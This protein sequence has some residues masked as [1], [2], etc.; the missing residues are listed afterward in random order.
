VQFF[1]PIKICQKISKLLCGLFFVAL[2]FIA[3]ISY[4]SSG[5]DTGFGRNRSCDITTGDPAGLHYDAIDGGD[6]AEFV[7]TNPVCATVALTSYAAVKAG[8]A[9][10]NG[11]CGSG[12]AVPRVLPS[13]LMDAWDIVRATR[14]AATTR[15]PSCI[16]AEIVGLATFTAALTQMKIIYDIAKA[17]YDSTK[18]CGANWLKPNV[19][20][21]QI[22]TP[23]YKATVENAINTRLRTLR[24]SGSTTTPDTLKKTDKT[25][26]EWYY[27]GVEVE[28]NP[29]SGEACYDPGNILTGTV[30]ARNTTYGKQKYYLHGLELGNYNCEQYNILPGT[31]DPETK[32]AMVEYRVADYKTA[33]KCCQD[34]AQNFVCIDNSSKQVFCRAGDKCTIDNITFEAVS[35]D[36]GRYNCAQ[37]YSLCP[38]NYYLG[39]GT[40]YCDYYRDGKRGSNGTWTMITQANITTST[41]ATPTTTCDTFS[42]IRNANCTYNDKAGKCRN[43]C[44]YFRH[45]TKAADASYQ[46]KSRLGSPYFSDA[47]INFVGDS[48]NEEETVNGAE[49]LGSQRHFSA[50]I[51]QCIK[52]T[53]ENLFYN[54]AGHSECAD[55]SDY[56]AADGTCA[57]GRYGGSDSFVYKK[58]NTVKEVSFFTSVQDFLQAAVRMTLTLSVMFFGMNVLLGKTDVRNKKELMTYLLK[59]ALVTYFATGDAWQSTF[60]KGVYNTSAAFSEMVF[61]IGAQPDERQR[62]GCQFG[63]ISLL[64]DGTTVSS[65]RTYPPGKNY[66]ALWDTLDC[67]I[68]RYLGFGP[69]LSTANI[70]SLILAGFFTGAV[71]VYFAMAVMFFGFFFIVATIKALHIFLASCLAIIIMV[72]VSP[73]IIPMVLFKQSESIFKGWLKQLISFCFQPMILFAYIAI[74]TTALDKTM[75]GSATFFGNGP[76]KSMSCEKF[77]RN[78]DGTVVD[79]STVEAACDEVGQKWVDPMI[80]SFACLINVNSFG[81]MPG[82]E[83]IGISLPVI[84]ILFDT[85]LKEKIMTIIRGALVMYLLCKFMD[86]IPGITAAL[87]GG[88][89]LPSNKI[90]GPKDMFK[91]VAGLVAAAQKRAVRGLRKGSKGGG[92]KGKGAVRAGGDQGKAATDAGSEDSGGAEGSSDGESS[93]SSDSASVGVDDGSK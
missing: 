23:Y 83:V 39:G 85:N 60:F 86:E 56:P 71:G 61:K 59:I 38:Y 41:S 63:Y 30:D 11:I 75:I 74:F 79:D 66:L 72:F 84:K 19:N 58:G 82:F 49:I 87:I 88:D 52:E 18:V 93:A 21:Y 50:P 62:D 64:T 46:Y 35:F 81:T 44:Q 14:A 70:A 4:A 80:D 40:D 34:R 91:K 42:E 77:C 15:S 45:C 57:S 92:S 89:A 28:D 3:E 5:S 16:A 9:A 26:R 48:K 55:D 12:S 37:S 27:G 36:N 90:G 51:A 65:G 76:M 32:L 33:Y 13:P 47:C 10:M 22:T 24:N 6:D 25:Y 8:I 69:S 1:P 78:V 53:L 29:D 73:I 31:N 17:S 67:K 20:T 2:L 43:Y 68:A 7:M 54:R